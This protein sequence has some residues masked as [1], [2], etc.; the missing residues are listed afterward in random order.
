LGYRTQTAGEKLEEAVDQHQ[1]PHVL[2]PSP[3]R[4]R[5]KLRILE[6]LVGSTWVGLERDGDAGRRFKE[7][8]AG[9]RD[10]VCTV[11]YPLNFCPQGYFMVIY[12]ACATNRTVTILWLLGFWQGLT[13]ISLQ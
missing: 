5:D 6:G 2:I 10:V 9:C 1:S 3:C 4:W 8:G 11:L 13:L 12:Q 7:Q